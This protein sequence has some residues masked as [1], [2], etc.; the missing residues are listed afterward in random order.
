[1]IYPVGEHILSDVLV[2]LAVEEISEG[3]ELKFLNP[4]FDFGEIEAMLLTHSRHMDPDGLD[5]R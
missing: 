1:M 4:S 2:D 3:L 5:D